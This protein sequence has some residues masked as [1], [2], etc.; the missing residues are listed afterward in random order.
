M[1]EPL[2]IIY[3]IHPVMEALRSKKR[4]VTQLLSLIHI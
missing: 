1:N 4:N 3:G 2:D